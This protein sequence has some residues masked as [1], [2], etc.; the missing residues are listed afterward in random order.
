MVPEYFKRF[1]ETRI[2]CY[3]PTVSEKDLANLAFAGL[4]SY[5]KDRME[6]HDFT[7]VNQV[8]RRA[9]VQENHA[10]DTRSYSRFKDGSGR[11]KEKHRVNYVEDEL[12]SDEDAEIC[13]AEWVDNPKPISCSFLKPRTG[14]KDEMK[15]TFNVSKCDKLFDV[16]VK[17]GVIRLKEGHNIPVAEAIAKRKYCKWHDSYSHTT[18]KCNYFHR[19][20]QSVLNN[21]RLTLGDGN[22]MKLDVDP[23]LVITVG[24]EA[25]KILVHSNQKEM[26]K[27]KNVVILDELRKSLIKP[28]S[29]E[30]RV[31]KDNVVRRPPKKVKPTCDMLIDKYVHQ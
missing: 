27:G 18:N 3:N 8:L 16:L 2:R 28:K 31:W 17:G 1:R 21:G 20:V 26:T 22:K 15:Y 13:V 24:F 30:V 23:F 4:S 7:D 5:L 14:R 11:E 12:T 9:L 6:G 19:Q 29:P 25:K 10:K